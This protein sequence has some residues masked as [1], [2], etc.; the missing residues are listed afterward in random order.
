MENGLP[1]VRCANNGLTCWV[2]EQGLMNDVFFPDT[3]DIYGV[4]YKIVDIPLSASRRRSPTFYCQHGD[5][6]GW[7][8]AGLSGIV[9]IWQFVDKRG[10]SVQVPGPE[11][12]LRNKIA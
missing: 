11:S 1:L 10:R 2:D 12:E 8:C 9:V 6:F 4:G 5:W 3:R 7:G